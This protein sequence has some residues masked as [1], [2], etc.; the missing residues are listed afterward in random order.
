M[1]CINRSFLGILRVQKGQIKT[2]GDYVFNETLY[3]IPSEVLAFPM[4]ILV[5]LYKHRW[6]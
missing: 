3:F 2:N 5:L 4:I 6:D 1:I